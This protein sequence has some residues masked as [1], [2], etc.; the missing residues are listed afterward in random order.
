MK[1]YKNEYTGMIIEVKGE[2]TAGPWK[3]ITGNISVELKA[4][5]TVEAKEPTIAELREKAKKYGINSF[6]KSADALK[7]MIQEHEVTQNAKVAP[8]QL[9]DTGAVAQ[10]GG[11][12]IKA[13]KD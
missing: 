1:R 7:Q 3:E 10:Q 5:E 11:A 9:P 2:I 12:V 6:G 13:R 8:V 4:A